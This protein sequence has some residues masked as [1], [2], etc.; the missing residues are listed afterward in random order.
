M[1]EEHE[2]A[3]DVEKTEPVQPKKKK[4]D[5]KSKYNIWWIKATIISL[6]LAAFFSYLSELTS[7]AQSVAIVVVLLFLLIIISIIADMIGVAIQS[8]DITPFVS[9]SA[10]KIRGAKT[11][12]WV[13]KNAVT[14][15]SIL[16]DIIGDCF[17][18]ISGA[19]AAIIVIKITSSVA[20]EYKILISIAISAVVSA[21]TIGGKA[22]MKT[23]ADKKS[24]EIVFGFSKF[25]ALFN[26][27]EPKKSTKN[28]ESK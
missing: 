15:S 13:K 22:L 17:G 18:I 10:R 2:K 1:K 9:M 8:C 3:L 14:F 6:I 27:N 4:K 24:K 26:K 19:C 5:Q 12:V 7:S 25:L 20:P 16:N 11:A 28:K 23:V 21:F